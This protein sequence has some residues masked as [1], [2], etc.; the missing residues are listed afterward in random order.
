MAKFS[1]IEIQQ[2]WLGNILF[3]RWNCS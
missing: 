3:P 2:L 1:V